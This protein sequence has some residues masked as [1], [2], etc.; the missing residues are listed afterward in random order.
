MENW[1]A[2]SSSRGGNS[3]TRPENFAEKALL[4]NSLGLGGETSLVIPLPPRLPLTTAP[5]VGSIDNGLPPVPPPPWPAPPEPPAPVPADARWT[6]VGE[7]ISGVTESSS[8][9]SSGSV[10]N[11]RRRS[12]GRLLLVVASIARPGWKRAQ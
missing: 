11:R 12:I 9:P 7:P 6:H 1:R 8:R 2:W 4:L 10:A 3:W 5:V